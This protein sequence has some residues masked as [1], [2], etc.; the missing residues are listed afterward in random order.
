MTPTETKPQEKK[1]GF[2]WASTRRLAA[3]SVTE[4]E[5]DP[6]TELWATDLTATKG[7][8]FDV[9]GYSVFSEQG[10]G[11]ATSDEVDLQVPLSG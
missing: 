8:G 3:L 4:A 10:D 1:R 11:F 6:A 7:L 2:R 5:K 9:S